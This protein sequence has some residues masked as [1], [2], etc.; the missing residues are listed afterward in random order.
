MPYIR[1]VLNLNISLFPSDPHEKLNSAYCRFDLYT[2]MFLTIHTNKIKNKNFFFLFKF[3]FFC[4]LELCQRENI[5]LC[6]QEK[7]KHLSPKLFQYD[8]HYREYLQEKCIL[9]NKSSIFVR[10][11]SL[12]IVTGLELQGIL[13]SSFR[14]ELTQQQLQQ[15][16]Q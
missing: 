4:N 7:K 1:L 10:K 16:S 6:K 5:F 9:T 3:T 12:N 11:L 15:V 13:A 8:W 14:Q 2:F